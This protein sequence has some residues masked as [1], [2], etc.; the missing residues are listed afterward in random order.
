MEWKLND[1]KCKPLLP[2]HVSVCMCL[3][4]CM[5]TFVCILH[6]CGL[7]ASGEKSLQGKN[8]SL[9]FWQ[10]SFSFPPPYSYTH[11]S[12]SLENDWLFGL[13][14]QLHVCKLN[15]PFLSLS[16]FPKIYCFSF[17]QLFILILSPLTCSVTQLIT[18]GRKQNINFGIPKLFVAHA[19][20]LK[21]TFIQAIE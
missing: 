9:S 13:V 18:Q 17:I 4:A 2:S 20:D 11:A 14:S 19:D 8:K 6:T 7:R 10:L 15:S 12:C 3:Y 16:V 1:E 21:V 5:N